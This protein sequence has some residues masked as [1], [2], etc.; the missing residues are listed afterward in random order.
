[1]HDFSRRGGASWEEVKAWL[2]IGDRSRAIR[3]AW[4]KLD[5]ENREIMWTRSGMNRSRIGLTIWAL[6]LETSFNPD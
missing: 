6:Y 4:W 2:W 1:L 3:S 5:E